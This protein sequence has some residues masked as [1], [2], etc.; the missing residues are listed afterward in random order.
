F[1][2]MVYLNITSPP[3]NMTLTRLLEDG[4][5]DLFQFVESDID[6]VFPIDLGLLE[7]YYTA[8]FSNL[9]VDYLFDMI[10]EGNTLSVPK[11]PNPFNVSISDWF[12]PICRFV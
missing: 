11:Y 5:S 10:A 2:T 7:D 3:K 12:M 1:T 8:S 6:K 9:Y 4:N